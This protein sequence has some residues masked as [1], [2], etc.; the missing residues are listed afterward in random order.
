MTW[1]V[2]GEVD[3]GVRGPRALDWSLRHWGATDGA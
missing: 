3:I 2:E 1:V